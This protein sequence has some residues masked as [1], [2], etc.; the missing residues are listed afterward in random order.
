M[1]CLEFSKGI[2]RQRQQHA[3]K[4]PTPKQGPH[5]STLPCTNV[6]MRSVNSKA[7][8]GSSIRTQPHVGRGTRYGRC[9]SGAAMRSQTNAANSVSSA[10]QY[11]A[12][13]RLTMLV[14]SNCPCGPQHTGQASSQR[15]RGQAC[16]AGGA[17]APPPCRRG[18]GLP[19]ARRACGCVCPPRPHRLEARSAPGDASLVVRCEPVH[20]GGAG[21]ARMGVWLMRLV[22]CGG[23]GRRLAD[24]GPRQTP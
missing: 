6:I 18:R 11:T 17:H 4:Q 9:S 24:T 21:W 22:T 13:S 19:P 3:A 15:G 7:E 20:A 1:L 12:F 8:A 14:K 10:R 5:T 16:T 23:E 2:N